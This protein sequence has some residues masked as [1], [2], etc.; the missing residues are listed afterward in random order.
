MSELA[1]RMSTLTYP[2]P[3]LTPIVGRPDNTTIQVLQKEIYAN[4]KAIDS[5][6]GGGQN[7]HLAIVMA[8]PAYL[9]RSGVVFNAPVHPGDAPE[10]AVGATTAQITETNRRFKYDL[11]DHRLFRTVSEELKQQLLLAVPHRY[12][13]VFED[14]D[15]GYADVT[16]LTILTHL[17]TV[18]AVVEPE[19]IDKNREKLS[20]PWNPDDP[21][22]ELWHRI[23][24]IQRFASASEEE[25]TDSTALRLTLKVF[26]ATGVFITDTEKWRDKDLIDWTMDNFQEHFNKATKER[27]RKLTAQTAGFHGAHSAVIVTPPGAAN[28][29]TPATPA[30]TTAVIPPGRASDY[31]YC[32]THGLGKNDKHTSLLCENRA[33]GHK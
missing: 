33:P 30:G 27:T 22:E 14:V 9:A 6:R 5:T 21:I 16:V 3:V 25:I 28:A 11:A 8:A 19:D 17:K 13:R 15:M 18:Y 24:E 31:F 10:H 26:D 2:H 12:F 1:S 20:T 23:S 4:A 29:L 7:G 32:W